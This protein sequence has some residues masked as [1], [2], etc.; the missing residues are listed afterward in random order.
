M[1]TIDDLRRQLDALGLPGTTAVVIAKDGE[2]NAFSPL[3]E[4]EASMYAS[5][6][7]GAG[8]RYDEGDAPGA[9]VPAVFLWPTR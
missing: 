8:E 1:I 3:H 6:G 7:L 4:A 9:A 5:A 2:G